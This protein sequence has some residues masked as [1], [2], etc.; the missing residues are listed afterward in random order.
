[1]IGKLVG[2]A[3]EIEQRL[4][5]ARGVGEHGADVGGAVH[6]QLIAGF[7]GQ[8]LYGLDDIVHQRRQQEIFRVQ[9]HFPGFD[10]GQIKNVVDQRQQVARRAQY[11][12]KRLEL[13]LALKVLRV[14]EQHFGDADNGIQR[15]AQLVRH[16]GKK[17]RFELA[18]RLELLAL[19]LDL[20]E[21]ARILD[22][23]HRL[24]GEGLQ[25]RYRGIR[26]QAAFRAA[27][28]QRADHLLIADQRHAEIR[29]Y[30]FAQ[31][32]FAQAVTRFLFNIGYLHRTALL[33]AARAHRS[34]G[35]SSA[36]LVQR[37]Q[38]RLTDAVIR[39]R[40][41][42]LSFI[43]QYIDG[44]ILGAGNFDRLRDDFFQHLLHIKRRIHRLHQFAQH[45]QFAHCAI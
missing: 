18:R 6:H 24:R 41:Q 2:I 36:R 11:S 17:L 4:A 16:V 30:A 13:I 15:R 35:D 42:E 26:K 5:H 10:L 25:Q 40:H 9:F 43:I 32:E 20:L 34:A 19:L 37:H 8:R 3:G 44:A 1:M 38:H 39:L 33:E 27:H 14:F 12:I 45:L 7:F 29:M 21:Q 31:H 23:Q 22:R 28:H